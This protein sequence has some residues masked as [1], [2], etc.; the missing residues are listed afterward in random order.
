MPQHAPDVRRSA[1]QVAAWLE[2]MNC[3]QVDVVAEDGQPAVLAHFPAP[4]G[5]PTICLYAHHDVQPVGDLGAW[6]SSPFE[7]VERGGRLYGRGTSDDKGGVLAHLAALQA[8]DGKPPVG[9]KLFIEGEEEIG[10]PSLGRIL[11]RHRDRLAA[12]AFVIADANNQETGL[13]TFTTT[14]RGIV[15]CVIEVRTLA[16]GV[17]SGGFGGVVPDALTC[18]ARVLATLHDDEGN[19][20]VEGL[21]RTPGP[22]LDYPDDRLAKET[23]LLPGVRQIGH[24]PAVERLWTAPAIGVLA[25]DAPRVADAVNLVIPSARAKVSLRLA[26]GD[27][28][29]RAMAALTAH[30]ESHVPWG[31]QVTVTDGESGQPGVISTSGPIFEAARAAAKEAWGREPVFAGIGGSIPMV[32]EFQQ[33]FPGATI[34]V[35]AVADPDCHMHGVDESLD[36]ADWRKA[37][38]S[39][40][41]L[42]DRLSR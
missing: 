20:A 4:D 16:S 42:M 6:T 30:L 2:G 26:P 38:L 39:E 11:D 15:D 41:L 17:H 23:G 21:V 36:L 27:D 5:Q 13:P 18:L 12:D 19:V 35:T 29:A 34:L 40:V 22:D 33:Q 9:V 3:P 24:G 37:A 14:L 8:F 7:A 28:A 25:I 1:D 32:A 31:A 10:S